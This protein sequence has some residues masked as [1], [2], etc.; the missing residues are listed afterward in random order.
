MTVWGQTQRREW[1][2]WIMWGHLRICE[3]ICTIFLHLGVCS[4]G[5][6]HMEATMQ[7]NTPMVR[8]DDL[9]VYLSGGS[10]RSIIPT[11]PLNLMRSSSL[12]DAHTLV[13]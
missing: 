13:L 1:L 10:F 11:V 7:H 8:T 6:Y 4:A 2:V 9:P 5:G 3:A 12:F